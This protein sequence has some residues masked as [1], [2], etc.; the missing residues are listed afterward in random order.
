MRYVNF[1]NSGGGKTVRYN[2]I[3]S[4]YKE[5]NLGETFYKAILRYKPLTVVEFGVLH[6]YSTIHMAKAL[7]KLGRGKIRAYD[8]WEKY[9]YKH[10]SIESTRRN[11]EKFGVSD[12]VT[13]EQKDFYKWLVLCHA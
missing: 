7:R 9:K 3:D 1:E 6:G 2:G 13:L 5:N 8:L 10:T 11:L 4:S 12:I